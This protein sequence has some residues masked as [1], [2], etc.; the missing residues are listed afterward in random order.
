VVKI[1][2]FLDLARNFSFSDSP[3]VNDTSLYESECLSYYQQ[4]SSCILFKIY[5]MDYRQ[6]FPA[7]NLIID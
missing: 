7:N 3:L 6:Y 4:L 2:A 5:A 1:F